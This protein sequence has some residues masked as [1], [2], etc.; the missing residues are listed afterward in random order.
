MPRR[1]FDIKGRVRVPKRMNLQNGLGTML[2]L[3]SASRINSVQYEVLKKCFCE[4]PWCAL[5]PCC[6]KIIPVD[7]R[8]GT[9]YSGIFLDTQCNTPN[10]NLYTCGF[11]PDAPPL[12]QYVTAPLSPPHH[13]HPPSPHPYP[14]SA[15]NTLPPRSDD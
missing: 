10:S 11:F 8:N 7:N 4:T 2:F 14:L 1:R 9:Y 13:H 15:C 6:G 12:S 5:R 3:T